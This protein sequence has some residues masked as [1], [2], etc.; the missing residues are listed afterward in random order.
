[1]PVVV[2]IGFIAFLGNYLY[3]HAVAPALMR[4][5]AVL[6]I[7]C[8][9]ALGLATPA[10]IAVGLGRAARKGILIRHG[11]QLEHSVISGR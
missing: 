11:R 5:I 8:P 4:G 6:V 3:L 7:A 1:M 9:C 2:A 10:A